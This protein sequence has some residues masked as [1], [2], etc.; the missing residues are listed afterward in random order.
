MPRSRQPISVYNPPVPPDDIVGNPPFGLRWNTLKEWGNQD[1]E[2][3]R[4]EDLFLE[5]I[6][7]NLRRGGSAIFVVPAAWPHDEIIY[8]QTQKS[9]TTSLPKA[10]FCSIPPSSA[11][12]A[13]PSSK[14]SFC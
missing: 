12:A 4:S 6:A 2:S 7:R 5:F 13:V 1:K 11:L 9:K 8:A 3:L 14:R 10:S